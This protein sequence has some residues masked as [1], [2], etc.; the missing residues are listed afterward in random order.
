MAAQARGFSACLSRAARVF[1]EGGLRHLLIRVLQKLMLPLLEFGSI[2]FF[3]RKLDENLPEARAAL[4]LKLRL[5]SPSDLCLLLEG[6]DPSQP[7][8]TLRERFRRGDLCFIAVDADGKVAHS[9]WVTTERAYIP[10]LGMDLVLSPGQAYFYNGFTRPDVR[11]RGIDGVVRCF[12]FCS[13]RAAGFKKIYSYVRGDNPVGLRAA[14]RWQRS[15]G[16]FWYLRLRGLRPLAIGRCR[17]GLPDLTKSTMDQEEKSFRARVWHEWFEGWLRE[18]LA[19]RSTGYNALPEEYF[20][21][22]AEYISAALRLDPDSDFVLDVGCDSAMVSRLVAPRCWRFV[23]VDFIPG[24]LADIP[25]EAVESATGW[26]ASFVAADG[27]SLP[28]Q[29]HV[30]TKAYCSGVIHTLPS[31]EDGLQMIKELVRVCR[32]GGEVLVAGVPDTGK[33][34]RAYLEV[35]RQADFAG[36]LKLSISLAIPRSARKFLRRLL[37]L[38]PRDRL[39]FLQYDLK[40]LKRRFEAQGLE[41]QILHFPENYWNRDFRKTRSNLLIHIPHRW[42]SDLPRTADIANSQQELQLR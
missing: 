22:A 33:R 30:F 11:G 18:P 38:A 16:R 32:P 7:V 42:R 13:M 31:R 34:F 2:I 36:K 3:M 21:S 12:I 41:C 29:S 28:F 39:V 23:G 1:E 25:Q 9:R 19:K 40:E 27:R 6:S 10:E 8:E 20:V 14:R 5:A 15:A 35:W 24:M 17:L 26:P 4:E 37:G